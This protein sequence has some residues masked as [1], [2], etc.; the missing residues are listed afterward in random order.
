MPYV[1]RIY[2]TILIFAFYFPP[3]QEFCSVKFFV[4][5]FFYGYKHQTSEFSVYCGC[6]LLGYV[7]LF[8]HSDHGFQIVWCS[9][10]NLEYGFEFK[11][12]IVLVFLLLPESEVI[13]LAQDTFS[14]Y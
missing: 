12:F 2:G 14:T 11:T 8:V 4:N 3:C 6:I 7:A 5:L 1:L 13:D 10:K 9:V